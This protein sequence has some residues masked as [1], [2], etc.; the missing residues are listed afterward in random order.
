MFTQ[1]ICED[2][3]NATSSPASESGPTPCVRPVGQMTDLFGLVPVLANLSARQAKDLRL[4][5]SGTSG[6]LL[7][8][9]SASASLQ[10]SLESKLRARLSMIGSTLYTLTWKPWVTPSGVPRSRLRASVRRISETVTTG[11]V[12]PRATPTTRDWKDGS[13]QENIPLNSLLGRVAWLASWATPRANDS[14]KRGDLAPDP[15]N[16]LPMQAQSLAGWPTP[17]ARDH[18]PAH[19]AEYIAEKKA[20]GHGMANLNDL[21]VL[22]RWLA[23]SCNNDREECLVVMYR[24]DG[25]KNQQR[26]QDFAAICGPARLTVSGVMLTGSTARMDAGGQLSPAMS[27]WLMG[28]PPAWCECAPDKIPKKKKEK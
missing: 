11:L 22:A 4:L 19:S 26:L 21:A 9:S 20:Q 13:F 16:G 25:T 18:F 12:S 14:E 2:T 27:R 28:L 3:S 5:T 10:S 6:Q 8:T 23:P 7:G 15:R 1:T 24:E 17:Q